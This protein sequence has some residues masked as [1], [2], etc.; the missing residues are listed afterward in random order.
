M[1][2]AVGKA[3]NI[4][5]LG[6]TSEIG[7]AIVN[8][9]LT[10]GP[11]HVTLAAR[12]ESPRI[13][14]AVK[15]IESAGASAVEVI[16]FDATAFDTHADVIDQAFLVGDV[17]VAIVAFGTLGDQEELWQDQSKAVASAETNYTAPVS[18]G[19]LLAEKFK[20]QGH[21]TIVALSSVAGQRVRRSNFVYGA[22][23]AG[24]DGFYVNLGE[25]L[26]DYGVNVLVVRPGQVR[27]KMSADAGEAPL[28]VD[29]EDVAK[30]TVQAVLSGKSSIFVHPLFE[31]VSLAFKFIPQTIFRKLPF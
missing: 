24:M 1:L 14:A 4:L 2:N 30:A 19:V 28:T 22:S 21:G 20:A 15:A 10:H 25:A 6:G 29:R 23:K 31:Y 11:A 13:D 27:T 7:L 5:L 3:Q 26:R 8:E 12:K 16:D 9:F 18:V 17:D